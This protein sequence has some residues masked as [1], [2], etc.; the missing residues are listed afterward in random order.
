L[1]SNAA[2][3]I[4]DTVPP[5]AELIAN[6]TIK[7]ECLATDR[8]F[9]IRVDCVEIYGQPVVEPLNVIAQSLS[10][11]NKGHRRASKRHWR[12]L[13]SDNSELPNQMAG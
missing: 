4:Q 2:R 1:G 6:E 13:V 3:A 11:L 5:R 7:G 8:G 9:P 12:P 10:A